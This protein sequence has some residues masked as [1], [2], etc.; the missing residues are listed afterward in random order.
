MTTKLNPITLLQRLQ[1]IST[2]VNI[3]AGT[4]KTSIFYNDWYS[5]KTEILF[6]AITISVIIL[7]IDLYNESS[8]LKLSSPNPYTQ[9]VFI[10]CYSEKFLNS[11]RGVWGSN[12][13]KIYYSV[14]L[15]FGGQLIHLW[16]H[17]RQASTNKNSSQ[18]AFHTILIK[19]GLKWGLNRIP[20]SG[21]PKMQGSR[22][23]STLLV[24]SRDLRQFMH[25]N[26]P[27]LLGA[28]SSDLFQPLTVLFEI[29][30]ISKGAATCLGLALEPDT[31][32]HSAW[33]ELGHC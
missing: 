22:L 33:T 32:R 31:E 23:G 11:H 12:G 1:S 29:L 20:P 7:F 9:H 21:A 8:F 5:V 28:A 17:C 16:T 3:R 13:F 30:C 24:P 27:V 15:R 26:T 25:W 10:L 2:K 14:S 19:G 18:K 6:S 4:F